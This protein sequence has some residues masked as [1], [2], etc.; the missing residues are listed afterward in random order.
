MKKAYSEPMWGI[1]GREEGE[2]GEGEEN[3]GKGR[4]KRG[5]LGIMV[6]VRD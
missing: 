2:R 5:R 1:R 3:E 4:R 6:C